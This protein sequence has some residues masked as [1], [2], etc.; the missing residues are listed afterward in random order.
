MQ[1]LVP[2]PIT[3]EFHRKRLEEHNSATVDLASTFDPAKPQVS[4]ISLY[5]CLLPCLHEHSGLC[6][7]YCMSAI[8]RAMLLTGESVLLIHFTA[9][10]FVGE[11]AVKSA[12]HLTK[13]KGFY[14][15]I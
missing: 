4:I 8:Y 7:P 13:Q 10:G 12:T 2:Q 1:K 9:G 5:T 11:D 15:E 6:V 3:I 14:F